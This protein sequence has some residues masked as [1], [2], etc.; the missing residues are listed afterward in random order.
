MLKRNI[1]INEV[2]NEHPNVREFL[3]MNGVDCMNCSVK[4]CLLKDIL[5]YHNFSKE[6]QKVMYKIIDELVEGK[7]V[8][9]SVFSPSEKT[10]DY[11]LVIETLMKEHNYIKELMYIFKYLGDRKDFLVTYAKDLTKTIDY[12]TQYADK[13]H[14]Q[15]EEELLFSLFKEKD[16]VGVMYEEHEA[17]RTIKNKVLNAKCCEDAKK[18]IKHFCELLDNHIYK[19]DYVLFPYL[20]RNLSE[21]DIKRLNKK[22]KEYDTSLEEEVVNYIEYFNEKEFNF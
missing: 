8:E 13:H 3:L 4:T 18:H 20:D 1:S 6:D 19:E 2:V 7:D 10:S 5:E 15:K 21:E 17:V 22:I 12:L 11:T 9:M 14:H 16:I